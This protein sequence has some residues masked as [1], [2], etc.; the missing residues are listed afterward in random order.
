MMDF[1][2]SPPTHHKSDKTLSLQIKDN[3]DNVSISKSYN[4]ICD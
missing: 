3:M 1:I 2:V 4:A